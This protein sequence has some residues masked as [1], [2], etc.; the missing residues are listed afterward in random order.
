MEPAAGI[1]VPH[2]RQRRDAVCSGDRC[3]TETVAV[4]DGHSEPPHQA[5]RVRAEALLAGYQ[6]VAV[7]SVFHVTLLQIGRSA[8]VVVWPDDQTRAFA[9]E[10]LPHSLDFLRRGFLLCDHVVQAEHEQRI[11]VGE[12]ALIEWKFGAGL[13]DPLI[14]SDRMPRDLADDLL[15]RHPR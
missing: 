4:L 13:V 6:R 2:G 12:D 10:K 8:D 7:V 15:K 14:D 3:G 5:T 1:Q 9:R 11:R